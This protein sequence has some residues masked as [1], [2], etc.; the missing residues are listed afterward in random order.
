MAA[1]DSV[2][3]RNVAREARGGTVVFAAACALL[4]AL[5]VVPQLRW[6]PKDELVRTSVWGLA[7]LA[8]FAGWGTLL[9]RACWPDSRVSLSLRT[10]WGASAVICAG[11]LLASVGLVSKALLLFGVGGGLVALGWS[12]SAPAARVGLARAMRARARAMRLHVPL[13][14]LV[15][16]VAV[17]V[18]VHYLGGASDTSSNPY[19]DDI[20]YYPFARQLLEHGTLIDPFS[21]RRMSTLGGQALL[22]AMLLTRVSMLHLNVLDRGMCVLLIVGLLASHRVDGR[23]VPTLV[24]VASV[25]FFVCIPN[26]SINSASFYS[27]VA[28]FLAFGQ[29][30]DAL[31]GDLALDVKTAAR[32]TLPLALVG[33]ATCTLRQNYQASIGLILLVSYAFAV[34]RLRRERP[35]RARLVEPLVAMALTFVLV[36]PWLALLYRSNLTV[37]FPIM[38]GTFRAG[39]GAKSQSMTVGRF[40][41]F[42]ANVWLSPEPIHTVPLFAVVGLFVKERSPRQVLASQWLAAVLAVILLT[43]SF[44]LSDAGNLAR[45][46]FG[47]FVAAIFMTWHAVATRARWQGAISFRTLLPVAIAVFA[48][49]DSLEAGATKSK[50]MFEQRLRDV[51]ELMRRT[52][53]PQAEPPIAGAYHRLQEAAPAGARLLVMLDQPFYLDY[54]RNEVWN[55]DMAGAASLPP[56]LPAFQG[57]EPVAAYFKGQGIR[58]LAFVESEHSSFLYRR[59]VWFDHLYDPDE[60]W[61][62]YAPYMLDV[63]DNVAEL[64]KTR[65]HLRD[66]AGMTTLDL[67]SRP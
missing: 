15:A 48:M 46:D 24:R 3:T 61:R 66:E 64:A 35:L 60:I 59:D 41:R 51:D 6:L 47:F 18:A 22:H 23:K 45:Y 55:L 67:E 57:P 37:L 49:L 63:M 26:T 53:P 36:A 1:S 16:F 13:S 27:G 20:A 2:A 40:A 9:A 42:F 32:R 14:A 28:F 4:V 43:W 29:T 58:Y 34:F 12:W 31:G 56:D 5:F 54:A 44:S 33:A 11:G 50:A 62:T 39:V 38:K 52:V 8:A 10:A 17:A 7:L 21:F 25:L 19:D 30:L 65:K